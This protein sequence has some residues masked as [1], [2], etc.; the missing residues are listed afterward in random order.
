MWLNRLKIALIEKNTDAI[1]TLL[2]ETPDLKDVEEMKE[3]SYI[4]REVA[5]LLHEL[6]DETA[7]NMKQL[8]KHI[9]FMGSTQAPAKYNLDIKS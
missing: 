9:D 5:V 3:A 6:Q 7:K 4:L 8:K 1:D 2:D